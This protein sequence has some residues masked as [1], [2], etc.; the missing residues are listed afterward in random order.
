MNQVNT[1]KD[2]KP[3]SLAIGRT[4]LLAAVETAMLVLET[5]T[6][7]PVLANVRLTSTGDALDVIA[8]DLDTQIRVRIPV[9]GAAAFDT[10][11]PGDKLLAILKKGDDFVTLTVP[12][13]KEQA[14]IDLGAR[15]YTLPQLVRGAMSSEET[16]YY[17]CGIYFHTVGEELRMVATDGHR[18][19]RQDFPA[20]GREVAGFIMHGKTVDVL[21]KLMK[22]REDTVS[23]T[24][25]DTT[26][27]VAFGAVEILSKAIDGHFPDYERVT[28]KPEEC[29]HVVSFEG[30]A[31]LETIAAATVLLDSKKGLPVKLTTS[32]GKL[33]LSA[34]TA[35]H[36]TASVEMPAVSE[37]SAVIGF[38]PKYLT[39]IVRQ[40]A[41]KGG[42]VEMRFGDPGAPA[43]VTGTEEGWLGVIMPMAV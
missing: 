28:P 1:P 38:K 40:A 41:P 17:L 23:F 15:R 8:H 13:P 18:M 31:M 37:T 5:K 33:T 10:T 39:E 26:F 16:R 36:G 22:G 9:V 2:G 4:A 24:A 19:H 14:G 25:A 27:S 6:T 7:Y 29:G 20:R 30:S 43:R 12:G 32:R 34:G 35:D 11:I 21:S 42:P 3:V